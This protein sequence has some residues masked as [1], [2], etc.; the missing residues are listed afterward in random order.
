M[1]RL[2]LVIALFLLV[3]SAKA[4]NVFYNN[5]YTVDAAQE[6][7]VLDISNIYNQ[8]MRFCLLSAIANDNNINYVIDDENIS[9][10]LY[11][12]KKLAF[13][14]FKNYFQNIVSN[15]EET[16]LSYYTLSKDAQG[17]QFS[18]WKES[19]PQ[20]LYVLLFKLNLIENT[21]NRDGNQTCA[22]SEPFCTNDIIT[23][24]VEANP[25]GSCENGPYYGCLAPYT[26][27]PPF[28]FHMKIRTAGGF[29]IRM[30]NSSNVDIDYCCWGPFNDPVTPCP[31]QLTQNKYVDCGSSANATENCNIPSN[32]QVGQYYI[33][34]ITKYNQN[35]P[36]DISF[37]KVA[38]S[39]PGETDC[40]ILDPFLTANTPCVGDQLVLEAEDLGP[41]ASYTWTSPDNQ[42]HHGYAW[43]RTNATIAM[44]GTYSCHVV[45]GTQ[46]ATETIDVVVLPNVT[47]NFTVGTA[48]AGQPVQFTGTET[49]NPAGHTSAIN[50]RLWNFGDGT[51]STQTNP[52]HTYSNPGNY[53][54]SYTVRATG[55]EDGVCENTK[56]QTVTVTNQFSATATSNNT[57][58]CEGETASISVTASGG[59][60]NYTYSWSPAQYV[61][62]PNSAQTTV[63]PPV[64]S[65]TFTCTVSDGHNTMSPT[66]AINVHPQPT[67]NAGE[68]QHVNFNG[69]ATLSATAVSGASYSWAP[70]SQINGNANQQTVQTK[71]LQDMTTF[72]LTVSTQYG[73]TD[74]D[75]V[76]ITVGNQLQGT[77]T[78]TGP[79]A[80]CEGEETTI[81]ANPAGG[82][83]N[84]TY[85]W[86]PANLV[87]N[88]TSQTTTVH[89]TLSSNQFTC[90]V[91]DGEST[92]TLSTTVTVYP[93]PQAVASCSYTNVLG[94]YPII[95]TAQQV[96]GAAC[97]WEPAELIGNYIDNWT[98]ETRPLPENDNTVFTL[99]LSANGCSSE[100]EVV[101]HVYKSLDES[102][103]TADNST[104][105]EDWSVN[106]SA[107]P[108]GGTGSYSYY[109]SPAEY[110]DNP[111]SPTTTAH[112]T[113]DHHV[114][115]CTIVDN[116]IDDLTHNS[117]TKTIDIEV[118]ENPYFDLGYSELQGRDYIVPGIG[119]IPYI[120]E[121]NVDVLHLHGY[122]VANPSSVEFNWSINTYGD[123]PNHVSGGE[124][125]WT[126]QVDGS[127]AYVLAN[128]E[129]YA[130]LKCSIKTYCGIAEATKFIYTNE[131]YLP[132]QYT[133]EINYDEMITVYPNPSNGDINIKCSGLALLS[134]I[135]INI[136]N[137]NGELIDNFD[138]SVGS[139]ITSYSMNGYSDG[140]Y[141]IRIIGKDFS[142]TKKFILR[143]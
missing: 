48:I 27:R 28:W 84:Y 16:F 88:P 41:T 93:M 62:Y 15:V 43:T 107:N 97:N 36:T 77:A 129:G 87:D 133:G 115:T 113:T 58:P 19:L 134:P 72:T 75:Q 109:W 123:V 85:S 100:D 17:Q 119:I 55:G 106:L 81:K 65:T 73:C 96:N 37:Q 92:I 103:I 8:D 130:F 5:Y 23:F 95:L 124:S 82:T 42:E 135:E 34:V 52:T 57:D 6:N 126:I 70:A 121:Y 9:I 33:L 49:T 112:P 137:Y 91:N 94:G 83:G 116:G 21:D 10:S 105:C 39:G 63:H 47:S 3:L 7:I 60:G 1:K 13:N 32:A 66:V 101:L 50:E 131:E 24:H 139:D 4:Q 69:V 108:D 122:G 25:G 86:S 61:D 46:S 89:P 117:I 120:Y 80:I 35:V 128:A 53:T 143:R 104:V 118:R 98:V 64:G 138:R 102:T 114:F 44:A 38:G 79:S 31:S 18:D 110:V 40:S 127:K 76:T 20:D 90:T 99:T 2:L 14:V 78:I 125:T 141:L 140:L 136:Y 71:P 56:T 45:S 22:T 54:V 111:N 59:Y 132:Y 67:A 51:T 142:V 68:D 12:S 74:T 29:T 11:S 26:A 30:T